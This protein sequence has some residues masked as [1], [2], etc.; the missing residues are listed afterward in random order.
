MF[1]TLL[2]GFPVVV[3]GAE[4][5]TLTLRASQSYVI[6]APGTA[7]VTIADNDP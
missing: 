4:T 2:G 5:A 3:E 1:A 7:T 6:A